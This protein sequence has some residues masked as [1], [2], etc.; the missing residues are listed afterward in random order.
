MPPPIVDSG[1]SIF[2]LKYLC[3]FNAKIEKA[4][5]VMSGTYADGVIQKIEKFSLMPCLNKSCAKWKIYCQGIKFL[6][7]EIDPLK[8]EVLA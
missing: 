4:L 3:E 6:P 8:I 5:T 1:D 2:D 7:F